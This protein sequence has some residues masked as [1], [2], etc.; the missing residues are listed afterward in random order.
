MLPEPGIEEPGQ[1]KLHRQLAQPQNTFFSAKN[2][3]FAGIATLVY[4]LLSYILIGFNTDQLVLVLLFNSM[5]FAGR[6]TRRF[7]FGFSILI[8]YWIVF[9][10]IKAFTN[11]RFHEVH[12][13]SL[14]HAEKSLF[15]LQENGLL[16]TPNEF[17]ARHTATVTDLLCGFFYLCWVPVPLAFAGVMF[18]KNRNAF[19][20]FSLTFLLVNLIGFVGY[21]LYPAAPP[22]YV[23]NYG[24]SFHPNTPG[25]TG[26]LARFDN[27]VGISIFKSIYAKSSN[28]FAAMPSLHASYLLIVLFYGL[29][30]RLKAWNIV[31]GVILLGI[32]FTAVYSGHHY[33]LD[34]LAGI[35]CGVIGIALFQWWISTKTGA[36][37]LKYLMRITAE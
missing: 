11:F 33:V 26:G 31:F 2:F 27:F 8:I 37:F 35:L 9:V 14:Y 13:A 29:K 10:L 28:V 3:L 24:F 36:R 4:L 34:V 17:F 32:W 16:L 18:F 19:F 12:I 30:F 25:N 7:I 22:W 5:Y 20:Q 1:W 15:G 23:A 6:G 21:Y